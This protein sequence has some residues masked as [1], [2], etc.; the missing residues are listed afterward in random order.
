MH[1]EYLVKIDHD[2][3]DQ[4]KEIKSELEVFGFEVPNVKKSG[5][6]YTVE[7]VQIGNTNE[8]EDIKDCLYLAGYDVDSSENAS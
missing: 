8:A 1:R 3:S 2:D 4:S 6:K 7:L 5:N